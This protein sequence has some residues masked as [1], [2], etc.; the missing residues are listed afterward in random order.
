[1]VGNGKLLDIT[2][3]GLNVISLRMGHLSNYPF[4]N[5]YVFLLSVHSLTIILAKATTH[6]P[7]WPS[8]AHVF[9]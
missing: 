5:E 1:M 4:L 2:H 7:P 8:L 6:W 9:L 3:I